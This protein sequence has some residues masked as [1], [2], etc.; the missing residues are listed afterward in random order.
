MD[1]YTEWRMTTSAQYIYISCQ[2][3]YFMTGCSAYNP[4]SS[5][6]AWYIDGSDR[7]VVR[8]TADGN[9][10][11]VETC[12]DPICTSNKNI[13]HIYIGCNML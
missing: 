6:N 12:I 1:C 9:N 4:W 2:S 13:D 3:E 8:Q 11:G 10:W 7:C 5:M